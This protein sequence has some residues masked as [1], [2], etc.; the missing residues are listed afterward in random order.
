M[1]DPS[2]LPTHSHTSPVGHCIKPPSHQHLSVWSCCLPGSY[3][4]YLPVHRTHSSHQQSSSA[5]SSAHRIRLNLQ[6]KATVTVQLSLCSK[7]S[8][9]YL[10]LLI[11]LC[12]TVF[13]HVVSFCLLT[14][15][16]GSISPYLWPKSLWLLLQVHPWKS[17]IDTARRGN[18]AVREGYPSMPVQY[19]S[20]ILKM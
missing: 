15:L 16:E 9:H 14:D 12:V 1:P 17:S 5:L 18:P 13:Y 6:R 2:A 10:K 20:H 19:Q 11:K 4:L 8:A 7:L 3:R